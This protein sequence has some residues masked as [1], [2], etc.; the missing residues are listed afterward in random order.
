MSWC[1]GRRGIRHGTCALENRCHGALGESYVMVLG[2]KRC[3]V[4]WE[5]R[6]HGALG[7][8]M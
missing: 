7:E 8:V 3:H 2:E 5:K 4:L 6:C 1:S